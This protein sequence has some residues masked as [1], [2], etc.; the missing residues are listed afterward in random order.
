METENNRYTKSIFA[1]IDSKYQPVESSYPE[2]AVFKNFTID[3]ISYPERQDVNIA[4]T[5]N[6]PEAESIKT[7]LERCKEKSKAVISPYVLVYGELSGI[8]NTVYTISSKGALKSLRA[9][10]F[11]LELLC[12]HL[13]YELIT[14]YFGKYN[15]NLENIVFSGGGS[16]CLLLPNNGTEKKV[17]EL[18]KKI[19][20]W[21]FEEFSGKLYISMVSTE[22]NDN[23]LH[24]DNFR[25]MWSNVIQK[26]LDRDKNQ[27]FKWNLN[28]L[29]SGAFNR[30]PEQ[31]TNREEC[32]ICHRDDIDLL[33]EP[34]YNLNTFERIEPQQFKEEVNGINVAHSLCFHLYKLGD[35]LTDFNY[36]YRTSKKHEAGFES[37]E[38]PYIKFPD[39]NGGFAYYTVDKNFYNDNSK[40][41]IDIDCKWKINAPEDNKEG[42]IP[43]FYANYVRNVADLPLT[44]KEKE[45]DEFQ[46]EHNKEL[47]HKNEARMTAS[48]MGL[49]NASCGADFIAC[50]RMDVDNMGK[51]IHNLEPFTL[52]HLANI[53]KML[54]IFF[55][56]YLTKICK[57]DL[58]IDENGEE[59]EPTDLTNKNYKQSGG[60]N[61]SI[62]YA[63]GDDLFIIGAWDEVAEL[64]Y[65]IQRCFVRFSGLGISA[66]LTIHKAKYP[67]YQMAKL[68]GEAE[69]ESKSF[70]LSNEIVPS[71][72]KVAIFFSQY[73]RHMG[74]QLN[75]QAT[76]DLRNGI[77]NF[78]DKIVHAIPWHDTTTI[79]IVE[80]F[81][82]LCKKEDNRLEL[83]GISSGFVY[84][85]FK[86]ADIWW[87]EN[88]LYV[89]NVIYLFSRILHNGNPDFNVQVTELQ[90]MLIT[91]PAKN[92][93]H[94]TIRS[95]KIPLTWIELLQR[96]K[97]E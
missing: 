77:Q 29:F 27:K 10:S 7:A 74:Q 66:G 63:G 96:G 9:R 22:L 55:K 79:E 47:D 14:E 39:I 95:I 90:N 4:D 54:N 49:A 76:N 71:K 24:Q 36:I 64:S 75:I 42:C 12:E 35:E 92:N 5:T 3:S 94:K 88:T 25:H 53:S 2:N 21:A 1:L 23:N 34:F 26:E 59:I 89:P 8:Q 50:L 58:G 15:D 37:K 69:N 73:Y 38:N 85:L 13:C 19:N 16:F 72:N 61:V 51:V 57:G 62:V 43:F 68:S 82:P 52:P 67:L 83:Q 41:N 33:K 48:F 46:K 18:K 97:G 17:E 60:R 44:A 81:V 78:Q 40:K 20:N 87:G 56:V 86:I 6:L 45:R 31:K 11:M 32:Q 70:L 84:K 80:K 65:D 91:L 28:T 93:K 30:E